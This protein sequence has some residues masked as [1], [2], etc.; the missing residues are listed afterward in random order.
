MY[1]YNIMFIF[2]ATFLIPMIGPENI[3]ILYFVQPESLVTVNLLVT[4]SM[5]GFIVVFGF[6]TRLLGS[7]LSYDSERAMAEALEPATQARL[8][9]LNRV[10]MLSVVFIL[11]FSE[12]MLGGRHA[13]IAAYLDGV[14][15]GA[16][17]HENEH[18][19]FVSYVKHYFSVVSI[20]M[21]MV[22]ATPIYRG[23]L[24]ESLCV[25]AAIVIGVTAHG[26]KS[27][28]VMLLIL[29]AF[30]HIENRLVEDRAVRSAAGQQW[31]ACSCV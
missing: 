25:V 26:A 8:R 6:A 14:N 1:F 27:P 2:P 22:L 15:P 21:V 18:T 9:S 30:L 13:L 19:P 29:Y 7:A 31:C 12:Q 17:R 16:I 11:V 28:L 20:I 10:L 5:I 24:I 3:R 23:R 4:Y